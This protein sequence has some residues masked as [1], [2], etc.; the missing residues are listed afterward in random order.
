MTAPARPDAATLA[1]PPQLEFAVERTYAVRHA[2]AP[3]LGFDLRIE[4]P[5]GGAV[6]SVSF[7]VQVRIAATRRAYAE[8]EQERLVELFG[9][10][11]QW[12][13]SVRSLLWTNATATV[14]PFRDATVFE[15][16]VPCTYDFE[17]AAAKYLAALEDGEVPL[18]LLFSG[19]V[20]YADAD[21][22]LQ[23]AS[24][25]W[26]REAEHRLP[27][28]VWREVMDL[29]FRG[30]AWLRLRRDTFD[31]LYAYKARNALPSWEAAIESLIEDEG[32]EP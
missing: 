24:I 7:A 28:S 12:A 32:A 13:Q 8:A 9:P 27:V 26:D 6:R 5:G 4:R 14:P 29:H 30:S 23:A 20:F 18:E 22:R 25:S 17:V 1:S 31:R 10:P 3:T 2:A 15:L 19:T 11:R 16:T 21:G